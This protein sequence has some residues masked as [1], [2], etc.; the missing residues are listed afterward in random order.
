[1]FHITA[2]LSRYS[3]T[4]RERSSARDK[5]CASSPM[6]GRSLTHPPCAGPPGGFLETLHLV[7]G[8]IVLRHCDHTD[9]AGVG[10]WPFSTDES[11]KALLLA[12]RHSLAAIS[13][14]H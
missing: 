2:G 12:R 13:E 9:S 4:E 10:E 7:A 1:M 6:D 8:G 5:D 14:P 3:G 11:R